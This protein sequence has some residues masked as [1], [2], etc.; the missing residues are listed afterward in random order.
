MKC[1]PVN[2]SKV[3]DKVRVSLIVYGNSNTVCF[4]GITLLQKEYGSIYYYNNVNNKLSNKKINNQETKYLYNNDNQITKS[5]NKD[6]VSSQYTYNSH[7]EL[8]SELIKKDETII[9]DTLNMNTTKI[10]KKFNSKNQNTEVKLINEKRV[11]STTTINYIKTN[12]IYQNFNYDV[13][14]GEFLSK[15]IDS[16]NKETNYEYNKKYKLLTKITTPDE[17]ECNYTY[18]DWN[19]VS[20]INRKKDTFNQETANYTYSSKDNLYKMTL[21]GNSEY[22]FY[23]DN[24]NNLVN[25]ASRDIQ[26]GG[27]SFNTIEYT[28]DEKKE[29][30]GFIEKL[31]YSNGKYLKLYYGD[32]ILTNLLKLQKITTLSSD[33]T[34]EDFV[35]FYYDSFNRLKKIIDQ[36]DYFIPTIEYFYDLNGQ[37]VKLS[38]TDNIDVMYSYDNSSNVI[39]KT[40]KN[41]TDYYFLINDNIYSEKRYNSESLYN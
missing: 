40:V 14:K 7:L 4:D 5:I 37:V 23:Y 9:N 17:V 22:E 32:G 8:T 28:N 31:L 20:S 16:S 21:P 29:S 13:L 6:G 35:S 10:E 36:R 27:I 24:N 12:N 19:R 15:T 18:D 3:Y 38:Q 2:I 30:L 11:D 25:I 41:Y 34:E 33:D 1:I 39:G 26:Y